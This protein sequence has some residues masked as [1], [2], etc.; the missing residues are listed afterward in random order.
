MDDYPKWI[1]LEEV[2]SHY[3]VT[4]GN[5]VGPP[6]LLAL[7]ISHEESIFNTERTSTPMP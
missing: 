3:P 7:A 1:Y 6:R 4:L 2:L 5:E